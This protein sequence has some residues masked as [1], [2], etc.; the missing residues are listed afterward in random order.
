MLTFEKLEKGIFLLRSNSSIGPKS[1]GILV[2]N[3]E[4][5]RNILIDCNFNY[6][7]IQTLNDSLNNGIYAHYSSHTHLDHVSNLHF[8]EDLGIKTY[9]PVPE[10]RYLKDMNIFMKENGMTDC[11][12]DDIFRNIVYQ[13]LNFKNLKFGNAFKPGA[14]FNYGII[15]LET[16]HI[17]GHSPGHTAYLIR[18]KTKSRRKVLFVSDIGIEKSGPWYGLKHCSLKDYR[19]SI[20]KIED[21]Y[22]SDDIILTSG[23]GKSYFT[24]QPQIFKNTLK[25]IEINEGKVLKMFNSEKPKSLKEITLKGVF[26][27]ENH[28]KRLPT[29]FKK[30]HFFWEWCIILHHINELI[31]KGKLKKIDPKHKVFVLK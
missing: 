2:K 12:I 8:Y 23:H 18:D 31:E 28:I 16:F 27:S 21:I 4:N 26:Y 15:S 24:K 19:E 6:D 7:E 10:D 14:T 17:P 22:L 25:R 9:C 30:I 11:G 20:K 5:S 13:E 1:N 29:D 3:V